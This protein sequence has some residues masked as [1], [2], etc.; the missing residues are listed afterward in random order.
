MNE[1]KTIDKDFYKKIGSYLHECRHQ[2]GISLSDLSKLTG[3]SKQHLD[4]Y[5]LGK[6]KIKPATY[7]LICKSL[8]IKN[9]FNVSINGE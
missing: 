8:G 1:I 3:I 6:A 5:E 4:N 9:K 2:A 7:N